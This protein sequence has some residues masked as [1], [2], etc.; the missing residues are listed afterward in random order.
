MKEAEGEEQLLVEDWS[1]AAVELCLSH[2]LV[3]A[4]HVGLHT[5]RTVSSVNTK[6]KVT[7]RIHIVLKKTCG[8]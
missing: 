4:F 6:E 7:N 1:G 8:R 3:E 5:L 2:Q